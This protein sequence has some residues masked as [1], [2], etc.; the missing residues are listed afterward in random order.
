[1]FGI[2]TLKSVFIQTFEKGLQPYGFKRLKGTEFLGKLINNEILLYITYEKCGPIIP[3]K[4]AFRIKVGAQT[5]YSYDLSEH[6][7]L[8]ASGDLFFFAYYD[9]SL[10]LSMFYHYDKTTL[11]DVVD[12]SLNDT[13]RAA[14]PVLS[15]ICDLKTY[16]DFRS[17]LN[18][19][20][21]YNANQ[22]YR[23]SVVLIL[24][25]NHDDFSKVKTILENSM[26]SAYNGNSSNPYYQTALRDEIKRIDEE[27]IASRDKV[28]SDPDL[29]EKVKSEAA[30]RKEKNLMILK[31]YGF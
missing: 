13:I 27:L 5:I 2:S 24:S 9:P 22:L 14:I 29:M 7:L 17:G 15:K 26:L 12:N 31:S 11:N 1:M 30:S 4:K 19:S 20:D 3:G 18:A 8:L 23:D 10:E 6:Q 25:D 16:V 28:Y 21:F